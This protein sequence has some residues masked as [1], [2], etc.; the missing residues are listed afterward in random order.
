MSFKNANHVIVAPIYA[1]R[2]RLD[3]KINSGILAQR[4]SKNGT[5]AETMDNFEDIGEQVKNILS[6]DCVIITMGAGDIYKVA[7]AICTTRY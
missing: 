3:K 2:E 1:A 4:I 7:Q 5:S 6:K